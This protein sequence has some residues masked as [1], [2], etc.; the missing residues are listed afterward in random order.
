MKFKG[1]T[2]GVVILFGEITLNTAV[3]DV[4]SDCAAQYAR[5]GAYPG[6]SNCEF[7]ASA[8]SGNWL[9]TANSGITQIEEYCAGWLGEGTNP[10]DN[11]D[12]DCNGAGN[13]I[14]VSNGNK[15]QEEHDYQDYAWSS[16]E[17]PL[18]LTRYYNSNM[19]TSGGSFGV[20]WRST[21]DRLMIADPSL[22]FATAIRHT[23]KAIKYQPTVTCPAEAGVTCND[24][25]TTLPTS[26]SVTWLPDADD[27][28]YV[29]TT[30]Q[31][32]AITEWTL[33]DQKENTVETYNASGQLVSLKSPRGNQELTLNYSGGLLQSVTNSHGRTLTINSR[34][35]LNRIT[36]ITVPGN[37]TYTYTY[38]NALEYVIYPDAT[39]STTD[40]PRRRYHYEQ[41][42]NALTGITDENNRRFATWRYDGYNRAILSYHGNDVER[43]DVSY[44][45]LTSTVKVKTEDSRTRDV[46][47]NYANI[48]E[49][50]TL[51]SINGSAGTNCSATT[52]GISY[53]PNRMPHRY[54]SP[55]GWI[56]EVEYDQG[57][58]SKLTEGLG[59]TLDNPV[60]RSE[61][62]VTSYTWDFDVLSPTQIDKEGERTVITYENGRVKTVTKTD[63]ST[64]PKPYS[65]AGRT[66]QWIYQYSYH[67]AENSQV[68]TID[69]DGPRTDVND[70]THYEYNPSG[71]LTLK[72]DAAGKEWRITAYSDNGAPRRIEEP[73]NVTTELT[74]NTRGWLETRTITAEA[75][76]ETTQ[77]KYYANGLIEQATLPSGAQYNFFYDDA[78][79][80]T[81]IKDRSGNEISYTLNP[82]DKQKRISIKDSSGTVHFDLQRE[83]DD[84]GRLWKIIGL[85]SEVRI[86]NH[87]D[88]NSNLN[89]VLNGDRVSRYQGFDALNRLTS[90]INE[91]GN[92]IEVG[93]DAND[94]VVSAK[95]Q[96]NLTTSYI[97]DGFGDLIQINSPDAGTK[98]FWL[99]EAGNATRVIDAN[100]REKIITY[101][102]LNRISTVT[103]TGQ[104][105][106]NL[107][108]FYDESTTYGQPNKGIG[109]LTRIE[110]ADGNNLG[111]VYNAA[112]RITRQI[113]VFGGVSYTMQYLY[114][115]NGVLSGMIYPSGT[116]VGYA[117]N[118]QGQPSSATVREAGS[119]STVTIA[120][121]VKFKPFGPLTQFT[122][123]NGLVVDNAYDL[124]YRPTGAKTGSAMDWTVGYNPIGNI[125][126]ITDNLDSN[127]SQIFGY[128]AV[129]QLTS[130]QSA[131]G[132][133]STFDYDPVGNR[134]L[135]TWNRGGESLSE[136]LSTN[137]TSSNRLNNIDRT[138]NGTQSSLA[139]GYN[140]A[141]SVVSI[142]DQNFTIDRNE[143]IQEVRKSGTLVATY[144]YNG[145]GQRVQKSVQANTE[146][147]R[148]FIYSTDGKL[149][150]EMNLAGEP[151]RDYVYLDGK[152]VSMVDAASAN[153]ADV[154]IGFKKTD[155]KFKK[156]TGTISYQII[157]TNNGPGAASNVIA[158]QTLPAEVALASATTTAGACDIGTRTCQL[159]SLTSKQV[160]TVDVV[161]S[162]ANDQ[163]MDFT[164]SVKTDSV[165]INSA[166]NTVTLKMGGAFGWVLLVI[167][168]GFLAIRRWLTDP[169]A[170]KPVALSVLTI[171]GAAG[172]SR[173]ANAEIYYVSTDHRGAPQVITDLNKNT[174]WKGNYKPF[175]EVEVVTGYIENNVRFPGQYFDSETGLHYN[176][177]RDYDPSLGRYLQSDPIGLRGGI[178]IYAYANSNP[179]WFIDP[180]GLATVIPGESGDTSPG[181]HSGGDL[182][183]IDGWYPKPCMV[184]C[185]DGHKV[186]FPNGDDNYDSLTDTN[187]QDRSPG[188]EADHHNNEWDP[189]DLENQ[190][191]Y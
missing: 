54:Q 18:S 108:F 132:G 112:G 168:A 136:I 85:N 189:N 8:S 29:V 134:T 188:Q 155:G 104:S 5:N 172:F 48:N 156:D 51:T 182:R 175:G 145:I 59:G 75:V 23:G 164:A 41:Q 43:V 159:G 93:Y 113:V 60:A 30:L 66:R 129:N 127:Y 173:G 111:F 110:Q 73:N 142:G 32:G 144:Q 149:L 87:Y 178:N 28:S 3:A 166:N 154:S 79:R 61:T 74:Y 20:L 27:Y 130:A 55:E 19:S 119:S 33:Y 67:D 170:M 68:A 58:I 185:D 64:A 47:Y 17:I 162:T 7:A 70:V 36:S 163:K 126:T 121:A 80:L 98:T 148:R 141:G 115:P 152:L 181:D 186:P 116:Q 133:N 135:K 24:F 90:R 120:N 102:A 16:N 76:S 171:I 9:C 34:D 65:V 96:N 25:L 72:R 150:A 122:M 62:R 50:K 143:R 13:P 31:S 45:D 100:N 183:P 42:H 88:N 40:N 151:V 35:I 95:D 63:T 89:Q 146:S 106:K 37:K 1:M 165:D 81:S 101:D 128:N 12:P 147:S 82:L 94:S 77:Y 4:T 137:V 91:A 26:G 176:Y 174:V 99:D 83:F 69:I 131:R 21:Y 44:G 153:T 52:R 169:V 138:Q 123:G 160:V 103:Y 187:S 49:L 157:V 107:A 84:L 6:M 109:K 191:C 71:F 114:S 118:T 158:S 39:A 57:K 92:D 15:Y 53:Y 177:F 180:L 38:G 184:Q 46:I 117:Y 14:N 2:L 140:T 56:S 161:V 190:F 105:N 124:H 86:E 78:Q 125:E 11:G 22:T 139:L 10:N 97:Y 167:M 179:I